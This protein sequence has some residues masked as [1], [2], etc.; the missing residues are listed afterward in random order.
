MDEKGTLAVATD[1]HC[2]TRTI[3]AQLL[4]SKPLVDF[5]PAPLI[6]ICRALKEG[7]A[8]LPGAFLAQRF[9]VT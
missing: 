4:G 2:E 6:N 1:R 7:V 8:Q 9:E 3:G 5:C